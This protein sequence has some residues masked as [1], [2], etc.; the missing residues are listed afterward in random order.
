MMDVKGT[1]GAH[2]HEGLCELQ[3][4]GDGQRER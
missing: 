1:R 4:G 2:V 3:R